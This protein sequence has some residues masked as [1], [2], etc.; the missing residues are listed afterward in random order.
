M[1]GADFVLFALIAVA[2]L[3]DFLNGLHDAANSIATIVST[4]VLRPQYAVFWAAF[5]NFIAFA[6]FGLHVANTVGSGIVDTHIVDDRL[7]FAALTGGIVWNVV[8]WLL[9]IPSSSSHALIGGL[10]GAGLAK[11][12]MGAIVWSGL[13]K[14]GAA[15]VLSPLIGFFL[16]LFLV[17][18]VTWLLVRKTP[19]AVDAIFRVAAILSRPRPIRSATAAM[20]RRRPWAS[21]PCC[22]MPMAEAR[23]SCA[24][25][26]RALL[27][28]GHGARH[29]FRRLAHC[30][31]HGLENHPADADAGLLRRNRRRA[32]PVPGD[33]AGRSRLDHPYHH[34]RHCRGRRG[35]ARF[36]GALERGAKHRRRLGADHAGRR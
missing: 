12:G 32:H 26:G 8:T 25:L 28:V 5:F 15:I 30:P 33:G 22:S 29:P 34:R 31:H 24:A 9:G 36:G 2:L 18:G 17:L 10:V 11:G 4:R 27:P 3:F 7:I 23:R 1:D 14:T 35:A 20:T 16:A 6:V 19:L 13:G 21:S